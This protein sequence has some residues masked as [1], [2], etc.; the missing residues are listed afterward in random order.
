MSFLVHRRTY[1][2]ALALI[3]IGAT[4]WPLATRVEGSVAG[5]PGPQG[6]GAIDH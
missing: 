3:F 1:A 5:A 4:L 6:A 2:L